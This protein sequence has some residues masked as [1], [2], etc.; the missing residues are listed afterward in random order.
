MTYKATLIL[1]TLLSCSDYDLKNIDGD[2]GSGDDIPLPLLDSG[3]PDE[4]HDSG[5][6]DDIPEPEPQN[7]VAV[8]DVAPNPVSPPFESAAWIGEDSYDPDGGT[9]VEYLWSLRSM[10]VGSTAE[11]PAGT[12]TR[13][14]FTPD[15]AGDYVGQLVVTNDLGLESEP[16]E[17]TLNSTP[18]QNLWVEM[19]WELPNDDMD[20]HL[21]APG[22]TYNNSS[23]DCYYAN[24]TPAVEWIYDMD[25]G[26]SGYEGDDPSLDLDDINNTGPENINILDPQTDGA[27]TVVVHDYQGSTSDVYGENNVTVN[28][29]LNGVLAWTDTRAISGDNSVN[30]FARIDWSTG[31]VIGL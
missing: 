26:I 19:F 21:I 7:P 8:C 4:V 1:I 31:T 17:V 11:M 24:C 10:P 5:G 6:Q 2:A 28:V 16:C 29:Y 9:I 13:Y 30:E 12:A 22:G 20:L 3:I 15:L 23:T 14:P 27:Y 18:A 25:W